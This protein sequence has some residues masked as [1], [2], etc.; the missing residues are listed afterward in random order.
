MKDWDESDDDEDEGEGGDSG[1]MRAAF[2]AVD[3]RRHQEQEKL[4]REQDEQAK[5]A[6]VDAE[7]AGSEMAV[8]GIGKESVA[9]PSAVPTGTGKV[10]PA[11]AREAGISEGDVPTSVNEGGGAGSRDTDASAKVKGTEEKKEDF[12][13]GT[14]AILTAPP[15]GPDSQVVAPSLQPTSQAVGAS[16][17]AST[18]G[19]PATKQSKADSAPAWRKNQNSSQAKSTT[20]TTPNGSKQPPQSQ[21]KPHPIQGGRK[22]PIGLA[23]PPP[24][25]T[26]RP[27]GSGTRGEKSKPPGAAPSKPEPRVRKEVR[28]R[29]GG[30]TDL[31]SLASRV[32]NLVIAN[33]TNT[34]GSGGGAGGVREREKK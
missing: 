2:E 7:P 21:A 1:G 10:D 34:G 19:P 3:L 13:K 23:N 24:P 5:S 20:T 31:S 30:A 26:S 25:P 22:G 17:S 15:P 14:T 16:A 29:E 33:T 28:V 4:D 32:K 27:A 6:V 18:S 8:D 11:T 9:P 12:G